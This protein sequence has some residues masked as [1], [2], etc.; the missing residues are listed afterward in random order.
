[1]NTTT[2]RNILISS[3]GTPTDL[4]ESGIGLSDRAVREEGASGIVKSLL[5]TIALAVLTIGVLSGTS[6]LRKRRGKDA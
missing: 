6:L 4:Y 1:M 2:F 5:W 3:A